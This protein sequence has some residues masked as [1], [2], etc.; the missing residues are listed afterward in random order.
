MSKAAAHK[1][2]FTD[3]NAAREA[4]EAVRWPNGPV[5]PHCGNLKEETIMKVEGISGHTVRGL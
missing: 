2:V 3:E 1:P 5:W 4:F